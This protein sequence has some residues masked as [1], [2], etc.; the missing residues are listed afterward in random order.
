MLNN[1]SIYIPCLKR[2]NKSYQAIL[3]ANLQGLGENENRKKFSMP[4]S[5]VEFPQ[6]G[7]YLPP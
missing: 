6:C 2:T 7:R 4:P 3:K 1:K 5:S